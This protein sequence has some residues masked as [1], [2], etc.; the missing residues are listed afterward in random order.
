VRRID[1]QSRRLVTAVLS[2]GYVSAFK[3]AGIEFEVRSTS[4]ATTPARSTGT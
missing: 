3:G 4:T 2:G 1:V